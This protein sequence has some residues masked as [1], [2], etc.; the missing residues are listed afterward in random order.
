MTVQAGYYAKE[1]RIRASWTWFDFVVNRVAASPLLGRRVRLADLPVRG[2]GVRTI[3]VSPHCYFTSPNV[4]IGATSFVNVRGY[5]DCV[6]GVSIGE[7]CLPS[8]WT[9]R[10]SLPTTRSGPPQSAGRL[11]H[12]PIRVGDGCWIGARVTVLPG[13]TIAE[14][15]IVAAGSVVREGL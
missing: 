4:E 15:C 6:G 1:L 14:G 11:V 12:R 10:S 8:R 5:F 13:V 7:R 3:R 2:L 9:S